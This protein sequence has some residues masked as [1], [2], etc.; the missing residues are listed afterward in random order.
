[1]YGQF[2]REMPDT[3]NKKETGMI[4]E[5]MKVEPEAL[6]CAAQGQAPMPN[7]VKYNIDKT[8]NSPL[9]ICG[10]KRKCSTYCLRM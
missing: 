8:A 2:I 6:M 10:E 9:S 1:M 3:T 5:I 7:Y 4:K